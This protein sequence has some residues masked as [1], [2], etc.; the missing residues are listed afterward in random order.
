MEFDIRLPELQQSCAV[1]SLDG[2]EDREH[3]LRG[4]APRSFRRT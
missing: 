4:I 1:A 3:H 2:G